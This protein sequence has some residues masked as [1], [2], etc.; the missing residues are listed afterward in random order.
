M[1]KY[2]TLTAL[3]LLTGFSSAQSSERFYD[4][5]STYKTTAAAADPGT[6]GGIGGEDPVPA[7]I[8]DY[9]PALLIV[10]LAMTAYYARKLGVKRLRG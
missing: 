10:A 2:I 3:L 6:G 7:P 8:D 1:K 5:E 9:L 4:T